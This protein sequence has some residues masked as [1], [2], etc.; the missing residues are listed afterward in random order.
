M[1][2]GHVVDKSVLHAASR[3]DPVKAHEYYERTKQLKGSGRRGKLNDEEKAG[4]A[5]TKH[6][7]SEDRKQALERAAKENKASVEQL[8]ANAQVRREEIREKIQAIMERISDES[9]DFREGITAKTKA[10]IEALPEMPEGLSKAERA[11]FAAKRREELAKIRGEASSKR[12]D[13]S[14]FSKAWR[15]GE[16]KN[17][18]SA[19]EQ[20]GVELK[21][22][23]EKAKKAYDSA[24]EE[25]RVK[26]IDEAR[27]EAE[28]VVANVN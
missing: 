13:I 7:V 20:V 22:S 12:D 15:E 14:K 27:R 11:E 8:R 25:I 21:Q 4:I 5:Y 1:L 16:R 9:E 19:R 2:N 10:A 17:S 23:F 24:K 18:N 26:Y 6:V 3:Y 28:A